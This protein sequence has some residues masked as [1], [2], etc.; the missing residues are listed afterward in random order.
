VRALHAPARNPARSPFA[1]SSRSEGVRAAVIVL[2]L[3]LAGCGGSVHIPAELRTPTIAGVVEQ[4]SQ[5]PDG[6]KTYVLTD[7]AT[8][9]IASQ[10]TILLG[11]EPIVGELF[12]A[13][14]DPDGRQWVAGLEPSPNTNEPDCFRLATTGRDAGHWIET[15]AGFRLP[16]AATFDPGLTD[17]KEFALPSGGF[18]LNEKGEVTSYVG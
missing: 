13:G 6:G 5:Q 1:A 12:L 14:T 3:L 7:G 8:V 2:A 16:M 18:C 4:S 17:G 11:G 10:K 9:E 15:S